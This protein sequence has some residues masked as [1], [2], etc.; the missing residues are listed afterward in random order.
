MWVVI[1]SGQSLNQRQIHICRQAR[2]DGRLKGIIAVSNVAL[3]FLQD[4]DAL[5][6]HDP[7][8][9]KHNP[10]ALKLA[11]PKYCRI[12]MHG[13]K[14]FIPFIKSG[15]NSGLMAMEVAYKL[16]GAKKIIL[17][18]MDMGGTHYFGKHPE[19]LKNTTDKRFAE[20]I[21]QFEF[22]NYCEVVNCTPNSALK[23]FPFMSLEDVLK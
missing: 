5:V 9:W 16:Y 10:E 2:T 11:M 20:H 17:L 23:K 21:R 19:G 18:G 22:W 7:N 13:V 4:A 6:S 1:G 15:C 14:A 3:D 12:A 8:W